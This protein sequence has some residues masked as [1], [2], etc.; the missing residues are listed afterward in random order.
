MAQNKEKRNLGFGSEIRG[1]PGYRTR[2]NRSGLDPLDS[3]SESA[4]IEG[5]FLRRLF[6]LK[7]RSHNLFSL[8]MMFMLGIVPFPIPTYLLV[9]IPAQSVQNNPITFSLIVFI[10]MTLF[11]FGIFTAATGA[12]SVNFIL[13]LLEMFKVIPSSKVIRPIDRDNKRK[14]KQPKPRKD[15]K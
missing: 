5:T 13:S 1:M 4:Y 2:L 6:T 7:V 15:Y 11:I 8:V 3:S 14:K 9:S 12:L 10:A